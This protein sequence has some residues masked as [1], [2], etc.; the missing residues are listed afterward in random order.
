[1][2]W[3]ILSVLV[4]SFAPLTF[5][6]L[7]SSPTPPDYL[8]N[9][10]FFSFEDS[11]AAYRWTPDIETQNRECELYAFCA[12]ADVKGLSC[13]AEIGIAL[14]FYDEA[15]DFV[16]DGGDIVSA[17]GRVAIHGIEVGTNRDITFETFK[18]TG[19]DCYQGLPTGHANF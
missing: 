5:V 12:F 17:R 19:I 1:M 3:K 2:F 11:G 4:L 9:G 14:A 7:A 15:G 16:T 13:P 18:V 6:L 8:P 10:E